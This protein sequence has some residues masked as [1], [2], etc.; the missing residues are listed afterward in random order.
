[1]AL[2]GGGEGCRGSSA[3]PVA[4]PEVFPRLHCPSRRSPTG[5]DPTE[6]GAETPGRPQKG[7]RPGVSLWDGVCYVAVYDMTSVNSRS[8]P[9]R[10]FTAR[11]MTTTLVPN[12]RS[13]P[14]STLVPSEAVADRSG[15]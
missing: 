8:L 5:G 11:W 10:H 3:L 7:R 4:L 9:E 15:R 14:F 12:L 1:V 13:E 6:A 2:A